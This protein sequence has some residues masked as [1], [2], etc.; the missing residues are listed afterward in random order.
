VRAAQ[1]SQIDA[2]VVGASSG[3]IAALSTLLGALPATFQPPIFVVQH[4]AASSG[5]AWHRV[6][7]HRIAMR[8]CGVELNQPIVPGTIYFAPPNYHLLVESRTELALS[9]D[10]R[11]SWARPSID[12]LFESA[13]WVYNHR[14]VAVVVTGANSDGAN[15][16]VVVHARGGRVLVEDPATAETPTMPAA[17]LAAVPSA[18]AVSLESIAERLLE[19]AGTPA[20]ATR[21]GARHE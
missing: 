8:S 12:V 7:E 18:E 3:G 20:E 5:P 4:I 17:T 9:S 1:R 14:L 21:T 10:A 19:L 2:V 16:A 6:F 13:S 15:G 11:V